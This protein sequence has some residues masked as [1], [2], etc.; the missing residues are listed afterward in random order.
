MPLLCGLNEKGDPSEKGWGWEHLLLQLKECGAKPDINKNQLLN[1]Q[2]GITSRPKNKM[3]WI[4]ESKRRTICV[5]I[6]VVIVER[7]TSL[8][9]AIF[10]HLP[11]A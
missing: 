3:I 9:F 10:P 7:R 2:Y 4:E 8:V 1:S 6:V 5:E 11:S